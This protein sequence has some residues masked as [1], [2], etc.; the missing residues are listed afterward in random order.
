[1][2]LATSS[3]STVSRAQ[4]VQGWEPALDGDP[5]TAR[6]FFMGLEESGSAVAEAGW[7]ALHLS[8]E[9]GLV[10]PLY[11]KGHSYGEYVFDHGWAHG[12]QRAGLV[13]Y[14]KL[15]TAVPFT[16]S[17]G[18]RLLVPHGSGYAEQSVQAAQEAL[19]VVQTLAEAEGYSSWHVLFPQ[20]EELPAWR[21]TGM[22][23]RLGCQYH[24]FDR[25]Y[26]D[27]EGFLASFRQ[28]RRKTVRRERRAVAEQG[29]SVQ[30][31]EGEA[32]E[33]VHWEVFER[34]YRATYFKRSGHAGYLTP[35]FFQQLARDLASRVVMML[36]TYQGR[37]VAAALCLRSDTTLYGRYWGALESFSQLHFELCYYQGI[38]YCLQHGLTRFDPGA[39]GEHKIPRG[40]EP[41]LTHSFHWLAHPGLSRAVE[42]F[43][44]EE[45]AHVQAYARAAREDLPFRRSSEAG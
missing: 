5:T 28:S 38:E 34:C 45:R 22:L 36:A 11:I 44:R 35:A 9:D 7:Q 12:A 20:A 30:V 17:Q 26:G 37:Y 6:E 10:V 41:T 16:P 8:R 43:L 14:P 32:L 40:F 39:Q 19:Q 4:A 15:L 27:F 23:H 25:G 18:R 13:Y 29:V 33:A 42:D 21:E 31:V 2:S 3:W 1:M 24:W